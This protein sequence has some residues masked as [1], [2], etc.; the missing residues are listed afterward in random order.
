MTPTDLNRL[1]D[2]PS[3]AMDCIVTP[4]HGDDS[5]THPSDFENRSLR[6][7]ERGISGRDGRDEAAEEDDI[8]PY[9]L[10]KEGSQEGMEEMKQQRKIKCDVTLML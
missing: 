3:T 2:I 9:E 8:D 1:S 6:A 4:S 5:S 7:S 10:L